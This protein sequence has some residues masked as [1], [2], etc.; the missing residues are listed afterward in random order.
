MYSP[1]LINMKRKKKPIEADSN[2]DWPDGCCITSDQIYSKV[3]CWQPR[4]VLAGLVEDRLVM[5]R[6]RLSRSWRAF[7][8]PH[9]VARPGGFFFPIVSGT[10]IML[11]FFVICLIHTN[12]LYHRSSLLWYIFIFFLP[13]WTAIIGSSLD[14]RELLPWQ[15]INIGVPRWLL[16]LPLPIAR[17]ADW[18]P[19][20]VIAKLIVPWLRTFWCLYRVSGLAGFAV[21]RPHRYLPCSC[22][23]PLSKQ[24]YGAWGRD[25]NQA[26][27]LQWDSLS[28][29]SIYTCILGVSFASLP[30]V[31]HRISA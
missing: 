27:V 7:K 30:P 24:T 25:L 29:A 19:C 10:V 26:F 20:C 6:G 21:A 11:P 13:P 12:F 8:L 9:A 2:S 16:Y 18:F 4:R 15:W 5:F 1:R 23:S 22:W 14:S 28:R 3:P 31:P 17:L